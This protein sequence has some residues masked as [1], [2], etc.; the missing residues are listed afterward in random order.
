MGHLAV[1]RFEHHGDPFFTGIVHDLTDQELAH[2]AVA[3]FQ[4]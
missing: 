3:R 4:L 2:E 1:G